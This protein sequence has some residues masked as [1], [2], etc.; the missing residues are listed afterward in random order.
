MLVDLLTRLI[1]D[2]RQLTFSLKGD[3]VHRDD[4]EAALK[5]LRL[6][7]DRFTALQQLE[8]SGHPF[9][10]NRSCPYSP[11]EGIQTD[12]LACEALEKHVSELKKHLTNWNKRLKDQRTEMNLLQ[13][14]SNQ[15]IAL[16]IHLLSASGGTAAILDTLLGC[17]DE[18]D[19]DTPEGIARTVC[20]CIANMLRPVKDLAVCKNGALNNEKTA[21]MLHSFREAKKEEASRKLTDES[22]DEGSVNEAVDF[23]IATMRD[24]L[25]DSF[26]HVPDKICRG[27]G[28]GQQFAF[29]VD[30][31]LNIFGILVHKVFT[32]QE[33]TNTQILW[34]SAATG[35]Q[36][37]DLFF[38]R[39]K[40]FRGLDFVVC[41]VDMLSQSSREHISRM[42]RDLHRNR[43]CSH[44]D[45]HY[46]SLGTSRRV[47]SMDGI[48][49]IKEEAALGHRVPNLKLPRIQKRAP[50]VNCLVGKSGNGKTK[51]LRR[52]FDEH[53]GKGDQTQMLSLID[54]VD[55]NSVSRKLAALEFRRASGASATSCICVNISDVVETRHKSHDDSSVSREQFFYDVNRLFFE[56]MILGYTRQSSGTGGAS[57]ALP[58]D[59]QKIMNVVVEVPALMDNDIAAPGEPQPEPEADGGGE[60]VGS[61]AMLPV[62]QILCANEQELRNSEP[63]DLTDEDRCVAAMIQALHNRNH[64]GPTIDVVVN[65][66]AGQGENVLAPVESDD[67]CRRLI[68]EQLTNPDMLAV[69]TDERR[70][71]HE[72][73][74]ERPE[75]PKITLSD[76]EYFKMWGTRISE[77]KLLQKCFLAYLGRR[78][79]YYTSMQYRFNG[80]PSLKL[81][82][83]SAKQFLREA[84]E[85]CDNAHKIDDRGEFL[86]LGEDFIPTL[87]RK[88]QRITSLDLARIVKGGEEQIDELLGTTKEDYAIDYRTA[89]MNKEGRWAYYLAR[90]LGFGSK[91]FEQV[92]QVLKKLKFVMVSDFCF[93]LLHIHERKLAQ[94]SVV[95]EGETGVGKTFLL[96]CYSQLLSEQARCAKRGR[97]EPP[98]QLVRICRCLRKLCDDIELLVAADIAESAVDQT[99]SNGGVAIDVVQAAMASLSA[100]RYQLQNET[101]SDP[102]T[103]PEDRQDIGDL[104]RAEQKQVLI[105]HWQYLH[106]IGCDQ[107]EAGGAVAGQNWLSAAMRDRVKAECVNRLCEHVADGYQVNDVGAYDP[108]GGHGM[109]AWKDIALLQPTPTFV[110]R[111]TALRATVDGHESDDDVQVAISEALGDFLDCTIK[112]LFYRKMVHPGVQLS[113][114]KKW[115][116]DIRRLATSLREVKQ[117]PNVGDVLPLQVIVFFDEVNTAPCQGLFKEILF[118]KCFEGEPLPDNMFFIAAINPERH[119]MA[120]DDAHLANLD[121]KKAQTVKTIHRDVYNVHKMQPALDLLKWE[122]TKLSP[123]N[124]NRYITDK[125]AKY[126]DSG[127]STETQNLL[128]K[129]IN[130]S[131]TFMVQFLGESSVSQRDVQRCFKLIDFFQ[132]HAPQS[133]RGDGEEKLMQAAVALAASVAYY[134]RLPTD[135]VYNV[136]EDGRAKPTDV[137]ELREL[138]VANVSRVYPDFEDVVDECIEEFSTRWDKGQHEQNLDAGGGGD[139]G[140]FEIPNG[141]AL[142]RALQENIFCMVAALESGVPISIIGVPG[143]SKTLSFQIVQRNL[144]G[145]LS[146]TPFCRP[147]DDGT[148][149]KEIVPFFYQCNEYS[150]EAEIKSVFDRAIERQRDFKQASQNQG[151]AGEAEKRCVVFLDEASLPDE[152][153]MVL[154]VLHPYLDEPEVASVVISNVCLD[155]ANANRLI[156]VH[157]G[158][159][160]I[161]D[162]QCLAQGCLGVQIPLGD[163]VNAHVNAIVKGLC[164]GY[165]NVLAE[166]HTVPVHNK[167]TADDAGEQDVKTFPTISQRDF[168]YM[169]RHLNRI[170]GI[171]PLTSITAGQLLEALEFNFGGISEEDF[172]Q[173]VQIFFDAIVQELE[174]AEIDQEF[175]ITEDRQ[176]EPLVTFRKSLDAAEAIR[177]DT[178]G[179]SELHPRF[180]LIIDSSADDSAARLLEMVGVKFD[181]VF[182]MSD[183]AQDNTE[184]HYARLISDIKLSME[185]GDT[186]LMIDTQRIHGSFY[187]LFN[188]NYNTMS[189]DD[190][191]E[192]LFSNVAVGAA[193]HMCRVHKN[194]QC[195]VHMRHKDLD[196]TPAPFLSRFEKYSLSVGEFLKIESERLTGLSLEKLQYV[197]E[198]TQSFV[199]HL[200]PRFLLGFGH[201]TLASLFMSH[202]KADGANG[203]IFAPYSEWT[204][205]ARERIAAAADEQSQSSDVKEVCMLTQAMCTR[206]M[207][208]LSPEAATLFLKDGLG[209]D[210]GLY[211]QSYFCDQE[212]VDFPSLL[213]RL[214]IPQETTA[215]D[216]IS[217]CHKTV[218]MT[219]SCADV[220]RFARADGHETKELHD[221]FPQ[222]VVDALA[223]ADLREYE[224]SQ[225]FE[226]RLREF[227]ADSTKSTIVVVAD[228]TQTSTHHLN[229]V[230]HLIDELTRDADM[231]MHSILRRNESSASRPESEFDE[232]EPEPEY[233]DEPE[234]EPELGLALDP[235]PEMGP[236]Q[237]QAPPSQKQF[238]L[239]LHFAPEKISTGHGYPAVFL[240]GWDYMYIDSTATGEAFS[241]K[242]L[243]SLLADTS[244]A[245]AVSVANTQ[246]VQFD[247]MFEDAL[248]HF[249]ARVQLNANAKRRGA[250]FYD[251]DVNAWQRLQ[252]LKKA[253]KKHRSIWKTIREG[254][255]KNLETASAQKKLEE[256]AT[257]IV[258]GESLVGLAKLI[259]SSMESQFTSFCVPFFLA[260]ANDFGLTSLLK[261]RDSQIVDGWLIHVLAAMS[262]TDV[263]IHAN[264]DVFT[265]NCELCKSGNCD[266]PL[267]RI[268][269]KHV[270]QHFARVQEEL[271]R[272][273][274]VPDDAGAVAERERRQDYQRRLHDSLQTDG[275]TGP[276]VRQDV[277][278][279]AL[280]E[281]ICEMYATA[282]AAQFM[283][284]GQTG[285]LMLQ[286]TRNWLLCGFEPSNPA[287]DILT[288][289]EIACTESDEK[290]QFNAMCQALYRL[291]DSEDGD[292]AAV[293]V[294]KNRAD[295]AKAMQKK[296]SDQLW[297]AMLR[298]REDGIDDTGWKERLSNWLSAYQFVLQ[299]FPPGSSRVSKAQGARW[300][301][302]SV[303]LVVVRSPLATLPALK[304]CVQKMVQDVEQEPDYTV[305]NL[306]QGA[307]PYVQDEAS[308]IHGIVSDIVM[309]YTDLATPPSATDADFTTCLR[310]LDG[311]FPQV[312]LLPSMASHLLER[313]VQCAAPRWGSILSLHR[314]REEKRLIQ[315][316]NSQL[317]DCLRA[318]LDAEPPPDLEPEPEAEPEA[319]QAGGP[320]PDE[321]GRLHRLLFDFL[322]H[323]GRQEQ[324]PVVK[325]QDVIR[326]VQR[327]VTMPKDD[328][329]QLTSIKVDA[330]KFSLIEL[331][332]Q[333]CSTPF[334][335]SLDNPDDG[336][337]QDFQET[338]KSIVRDHMMTPEQRDDLLLFFSTVVENAGAAHLKT[339]LEH[340]AFADL[341]GPIQ[342]ARDQLAVE[343]DSASQLLPFRLGCTIATKALPH[344][345]GKLCR[346]PSVDPI[347]QPHP[348]PDGGDPLLDQVSEL[349][350][351]LGN[352]LDECSESDPP[353]F[354]ALTQL[355]TEQVAVDAANAG[356]LKMGIF[357]KLYYDFYCSNVL[358]KVAELVPL[359]DGGP[360]STC[361]NVTPAEQCLMLCM[362]QPADRL[363]DYDSET[364]VLARI[365]NLD[366]VA[367]ADLEL[368]HLLV[369]VAA[370]A[371]GAGNCNHLYTHAL[372]A[373]KLDGTWGFM[374]SNMHKIERGQSYD[375]GCKLTADGALP[376]AR[377][378][379]EAVWAGVS[380][381]FSG[382]C[383][384][385]LCDRQSMARLH[386]RVLAKA[387]IDAAAAAHGGY[388]GLSDLEKTCHFVM[389][390]V[391]TANEFLRDG[392]PMSRSI[393]RFNQNLENFLVRARGGAFQS[394]YNSSDER[395]EAETVSWEIGCVRPA[396]ATYGQSEEYFDRVQQ[397]RLAE[398]QN[399]M[400]DH[401]KHIVENILTLKC[402]RCGQAF[403]DFQNCFALTCS[404]A[405]CGC[406]F[407]AYCLEDCGDDAHSHVKRCPRNPNQGHYAYGQAEFNAVQKTR[408]EEMVREYL[409]Q[410]PDDE[411]RTKVVQRC[412]LDLKEYCPDL[413][414][415]FEE[416]GGVLLTEIAARGNSTPVRATYRAFTTA[417]QNQDFSAGTVDPCI[418]REFADRRRSFE[419]LDDVIAIARLYYFIHENL[420][421]VYTKKDTGTE[422]KSLLQAVCEYANGLVVGSQ[423]MSDADVAKNRQKEAKRIIDEYVTPGVDAVNRF[424]QIHDG[425]FAPGACDEQANF[426]RLDAT[427]DGTKLSYVLTD[428]GDQDSPNILYRLME[429]LINSQNDYIKFCQQ[430]VS[431]DAIVRMDI[432]TLDNPLSTADI[433]V[434]SGGLMSVQSDRFEEICPAF[435]IEESVLKS[436]LLNLQFDFTQCQRFATRLIAGLSIIEVCKMDFVFRCERVEV[437]DSGLP[438]LHRL[439][440][441]PID[442]QELPE[443]Q[444][445]LSLLSNDELHK[446]R[447]SLKNVLILVRSERAY[448]AEN[449]DE[450]Q[451][452]SMLMI[453]EYHAEQL[454]L[455][456]SSD[457]E[458]GPSDVPSSIGA[459]D[460]HA[461]G[462]CPLRCLRDVFSELHKLGNMEKF[463]AI[464]A[465]FSRK[466]RPNVQ[467]SIREQCEK[468]VQALA[469]KDWHKCVGLLDSSINFLTE[470]QK[471]P[472]MRGELGRGLLDYFV[473]CGFDDDDDRLLLSAEGGQLLPGEVLVENLVQVCT[474]LFELRCVFAKKA[475]EENVEIWQELDHFGSCLVVWELSQ[476]LAHHLFAPRFLYCIKLCL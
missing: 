298:L 302:M 43:D 251:G 282:A 394:V 323:R 224:S 304:Q 358:D 412:R 86:L 128:E 404:R 391:T 26:I 113:D 376:G 419:L 180:K 66:D 242:E 120:F 198:R 216:C 108:S 92:N 267:F 390:R 80:D 182:R 361:L 40:T 231:A 238:V 474:I 193:S 352:K 88:D 100:H 346:E 388:E 237:A 370:V 163:H 55:S 159:G 18:R 189:D 160:S 367:G 277:M 14:L 334:E 28:Q 377:V 285:D 166:V 119:E 208:L 386:D 93:K 438:E 329:D 259:Y 210:A 218:V 203:L 183:F 98:N 291:S 266:L 116:Q 280:R 225:A 53:E 174:S 443:L 428:P 254:F 39:V 424:H 1:C 284:A 94:L 293:K 270:K 171:E 121:G 321:G 286:T 90:G 436:R 341:H 56:A 442:P 70:A 144:R 8:D 143:S 296:L 473:V 425:S 95:I 384:T 222:K 61:L 392:Q 125:V 307:I 200:N 48:S 305:N 204:V 273:S 245:Q 456:E 79:M 364:N 363:C 348:D 44:A 130:C 154:K 372:H 75:D 96:D 335:K 366:G 91:G 312:A 223:I 37:I 181:K 437:D 176:F 322:V 74:R 129:V 359:L 379:R 389:N 450:L 186:I 6:L 357:L 356:Y 256:L 41:G 464:P 309:W 448:L 326:R 13:L 423:R 202:M 265:V 295:F 83:T 463:I 396:L 215:P 316:R 11:A 106:G 233:M 457:V 211:R 103:A 248:W 62:L 365:F 250:Q 328:G 69:I 137:L 168:V 414:A 226:H 136:D 214:M 142:N 135:K 300:Q 461:I 241:A 228:A 178:A 260:L 105:Q 446:C 281:R 169:L 54:A 213:T 435:C 201:S 240:L 345:G 60:R 148:G 257:Q 30:D 81:G 290:Q 319:D 342:V 149:F 236:E 397:H 20:F 33:P 205:A 118:D 138:Y 373:D 258:T 2:R 434:T 170:T 67:E 462:N 313:L 454:A 439:F 24:L 157:R 235:K 429:F 306:I 104:P 17:R 158:L 451:Q 315:E 410:L 408:R 453:E 34:C 187:D 420:S 432:S 246:L 190:G 406:G 422:G 374:S 85:L 415:E 57:F 152:K 234:P 184:L 458:A 19:R 255:Y 417:L 288:H 327:F 411:T 413:L 320:A 134:F 185:R 331:T 395:R 78:V 294:H 247:Q 112:S 29:K 264:V 400:D 311:R 353:D 167:T 349:C 401:R 117:N 145:S 274:A 398:V 191:G 243:T 444:S 63:Y 445:R 227:E 107:D 45:I 310:I 467:Q 5:I 261:M 409:G 32:K 455:P 393:I 58:D 122:Y 271:I 87:L 38:Q 196:K 10:Q 51:M 172:R 151:K 268:V 344:P 402:P 308:A 27:N 84:I 278:D 431:D 336:G 317:E 378:S 449:E 49:G 12:P 403:V 47:G 472:G 332:G 25:D 209:K 269:N 427:E 23:T 22:A 195:V 239:L 347:Q 471:D 36:E 126:S 139:A 469:P 194:F 31:R 153:K 82:S 362:L 339:L 301:A 433:L 360:L 50:R 421:Y 9:F 399:A 459:N 380:T 127:F 318:Q 76:P 147:S 73:P 324:E 287:S 221:D 452:M 343:V 371:L 199:E 385:L 156:E 150:T 465:I 275:V 279:P 407:C 340:N 418:L 35:A 405:G 140:H 102:G 303:V 77:S 162:L 192:L 375:S 381:C 460:L 212:H 470:E 164:K 114:I 333:Y 161:D 65:Y 207:Q 155:A 382:L 179:Y 430:H 350:Q 123:E 97:E 197:Q 325:A 230:R 15:D 4:N 262:P 337:R 16:I 232:L 276:L 447:N 297:T 131:Q 99:V 7:R 466:L 354:A 146:P 101:T 292:T 468:K 72:L 249:C 175:R 165:E 109:S 217:T 46:V 124:L 475:L 330:A 441:D 173:L 369:N 177:K 133:I 52:L 387:E 89:E 476:V 115:L 188:Q 59:S 132:R 289:I 351:Q 383:W 220:T 71:R 244:S 3:S 253:L 355:C 21:Q 416:T 263:V 299:H 252:D 314:N 338:L 283:K 68:I 219:R 440:C 110:D 272:E 42:Q 141:I 229:Y 426:D 368:R 206:L 64:H 111:A